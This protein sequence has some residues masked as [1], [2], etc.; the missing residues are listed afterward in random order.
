VDVSLEIPAG[1]LVGVIGANGSGKTTLIDILAGLLTPES[2]RLLVDEEPVTAATLSAWQSRIAYV[3][4]QVFLLD[5]SVAANIALGVPRGRVDIARL[6]HALRRARLDEFVARLPRGIDEP[7]GERGVSLSG[8]QRQRLAIARALYRG[9]PVLLMDEPTSS[10]DDLTEQEMVQMLSGLRGQSTVVI[11][12]H[13]A[14]VIRHCDVIFEL[15]AGSMKR[16]R[17]WTE[18]VGA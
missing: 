10:L 18:R 1:V 6:H 2:G 9:A 15:E 4:Q 3:P 12:A 13:G 11:V 14:N 17:A 7:V 16:S 5:A 8:G